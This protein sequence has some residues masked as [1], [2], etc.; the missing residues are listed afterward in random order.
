MAFTETQTTHYQKTFG[1]NNTKPT[2]YLNSSQCL[3][4]TS[5]CTLTYNYLDYGCEQNMFDYK[6]LTA[7]KGPQSHSQT[8]ALTA[9][10]LSGIL[11]N[12]CYE[13]SRLN[14]S[15]VT[16]CIGKF[17][18]SWWIII[19]SILLLFFYFYRSIA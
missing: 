5:L 3:D 7:L 1:Y 2:G 8:L 17:P 13:V 11:V 12:L 16:T 18:L 15:I 10:W 9:L 14:A 6:L 4:Y 19:W